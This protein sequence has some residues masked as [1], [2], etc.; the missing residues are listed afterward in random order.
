MEQTTAVRS[1]GGRQFHHRISVPFFIV[2]ALTTMGCATSG[3]DD[4]WRLCPDEACSDWQRVAFVHDGIPM[5]G[6]RKPGRR[7]GRMVVYIEGDGKG[8]RSRSRISHDPTPADPIGLQLALRDPSPGLLYLA[9]PCQYVDREDRDGC[10]PSLWTSARYSARVVEAINHA[11]TASKRSEQDCLTLV[12]YSGGGVIAALLAVHRS[13]VDV[14]VTVAA[15]LDIKAWVNH[16]Q[17]SPLTESLNPAESQPSDG[18]TREFHFHG[19]RDLTVPAAIIRRYRRRAARERTRFDVVGDFDH[20]CCWV[21]E[22][23][24][25]LTGIQ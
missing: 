11:I 20:R 6:L 2:L 14:L 17:V 1:Y 24:K 23:P 7:P 13:D 10:D 8:W 3:H 18:A 16:H 19:G 25:L 15:P 21:R 22:W 4:A 12:G 9:R 5:V